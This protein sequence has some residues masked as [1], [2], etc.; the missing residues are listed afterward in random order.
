MSH[1]LS[2]LSQLLLSAATKAGADAAD[3]MVV[4]GTSVS[5]GVR[6]GALEEAER[7]EGIDLGLRVLLGH[8]QAC[9]SASD[10]SAPDDPRN[11]R[12]CRCDGRRGP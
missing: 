12:A 11:G 8:R 7:A 6:G 3:A 10:I 5:I 4:Q 2:A 1:D 9:V